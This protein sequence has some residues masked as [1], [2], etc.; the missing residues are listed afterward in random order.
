MELMQHQEMILNLLSN[1]KGFAVFA[2]QGTGKT[3]PMLYHLTNLFMMG[4][5]RDALVVAP[6]SALGSWQSDIKKLPKHRQSFCDR[7]TFINYDKLSRKDSKYREDITKSWGAIVL[8]EAHAIKDRTSNRTKYLLALSQYCEYRYILTG[9]PLGNGRLEDFYTLMN[10]INPATFKSWAEFAAR[11]LTMIRLPGSY[12][13]I[14]KGYRNR[15]ELLSIVAEHSIRVYKKDCLDL[16]EKLPDEVIYVE[17]KEKKMYK[18]ALDLFIEEFD[19]AMANGLV[20]LA[21]IRQL[22]S[23]HIKDDEG[24]TQLVKCDKLSALEELIE[25]ISNKTVVFCEFTESIHQISNMLDKKH[26]KH[27]ILSGE[28]KDKFIWQRFQDEEDIQVIICQYGSANAGINLYKASHTIYYE[29]D[30]STTVISQSKDR[31]HRYGVKNPCS[32]YWLITKDTMEEDIYKKLVS[33]EDFNKKALI[34]IMEK[35]GLIK[36]EL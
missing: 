28:Q 7:I 11:Y 24:K 19:I 14:I 10:F 6:L 4:K 21:K 29:P 15:E 18:Q 8:D 13:E 5:I 20:R 1:D 9:T 22:L 36:N 33:N 16:P 23:G 2:E 25:S 3:L 27:I 26:I 30:L 35:R 32:Y 12:V 34:E 31:T 17:C